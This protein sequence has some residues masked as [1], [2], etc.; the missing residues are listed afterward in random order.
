MNKIQLNRYPNGSYYGL[1]MSY[2]DGSDG[3]Y[4]LVEILNQY[5]LKGT[6]HLYSC[7]LDQPTFICRKDIEILYQGHEVSIHT[8]NHLHLPQV[9]ISQQVYELFD[10]K[11]ELESLVHYPMRG[12]STPFGSSDE[13]LQILMKSLGL[14]Y[15][16]T[17]ISTRKFDIPED[18]LKWNPTIHLKQDEDDL[19]REFFHNPF[20]EMRL[21]FNWGHS[22]EFRNEDKWDVF[23]HFCKQMTS[24][25]PICSLTMSEM[26]DYLEALHHL[27]FTTKQDYV[28]NPSGIDVCI[29]CNDAL[30]KIPARSTVYLGESNE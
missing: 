8:T 28:F 26:K 19:I 11:Q 10:N 9:P 5:Q 6:F 12:L 20:K 7:V 3:D 23:E 16:R 22:Y 2:D 13:N 24:Y 25:E 1:I 30:V 18:Y 17:V 21:F 27:V 14:E 4:Q 15:C 29:S